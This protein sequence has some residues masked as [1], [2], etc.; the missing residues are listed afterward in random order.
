MHLNESLYH[1]MEE[2]LH[3]LRFAQF[4]QT[5]Q[6]CV[7]HNKPDVRVEYYRTCLIDAI[8]QNETEKREHSKCKENLKLQEEEL[9][10]ITEQT[11]LHKQR[12]E[13]LMFECSTL[14]QKLL[15]HRLHSPEQEDQQ[16][17][18]KD[19]GNK[20]KEKTKEKKVDA[21]DVPKV[22][23]HFDQISDL[24]TVT[25][26]TIPHDTSAAEKDDEYLVA[27]RPS[28]AIPPPAQRKHH[29]P[30]TPSPDT[31]LDTARSKYIAS[32][33]AYEAVL[34]QEEL[35]LLR[36]E[37]VK[38]RH[39]VNSVLGYEST[40]R[41]P[42]AK[43]EPNYKNHKA[44]LADDDNQQEAKNA[45][46]IVQFGDNS[47]CYE[48]TIQPPHSRESAC[49]DLPEGQDD[50]QQLCNEMNKVLTETIQKHEKADRQYQNDNRKLR[51]QLDRASKEA[52]EKYKEWSLEKQQMQKKVK[53]TAT[54][55]SIDD[56]HPT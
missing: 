5:I 6:C 22:Y 14:Q 24:H 42:I 31:L 21:G 20:D 28:V 9:S 2:T 46:K 47:Y 10:R 56:T 51:I 33:A 36:V 43:A 50:A 13:K 53:S 16:E 44:S 41:R 35:R 4:L 12:I 52:A 55:N 40:T 32:K 3:A 18:A 37:L 8:R 25:N 54:L 34:Q 7:A 45:P 23:L 27:P 17:K 26:S 38:Q 48:P 29:H 30:P 39:T 15:L 11:K 1:N 49:Y 19:Q